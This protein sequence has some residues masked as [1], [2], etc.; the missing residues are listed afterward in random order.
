MSTHHK[1]QFPILDW[2]HAYDNRGYVPDVEH[3]IAN[4][5]IEAAEYRSKTISKLDVPYGPSERMVY[6]IFL[7]DSVPKGLVVFVHGGYWHRTSKSV[8]SHLAE[9]AVNRGWAV[10]MPSYELCP[11]VTINE[12]TQMIGQAINQVA[13]EIEGPIIL[14]GHSA[15]GHLVCKMM[16]EGSPL[17]ESVRSRLQKV[18][19][20]SGL[21]DLR[22]LLNT[23]MNEI[24]GLDLISASAASPALKRPYQNIPLVAWVGGAERSE[25]L[26]QNAL[27][28]NMWYGLGVKVTIVEEPDKNHFN[29]VDGLRDPNSPLIDTL[30]AI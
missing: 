7:P 25:F 10:C 26:R 21:S 11:D 5:P 3:L 2:D 29:V 17:E 28:A 6:D 30:L 15:G 12:I 27:I 9:G 20:I 24:L 8:W 13:K 19:S 16:S 14:S 23:K 18:V 22:P 1:I 4:L